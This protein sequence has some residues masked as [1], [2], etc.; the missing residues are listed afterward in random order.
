MSNS[1]KQSESSR[2]KD[3]NSINPSPNSAAAIIKAAKHTL[4]QLETNKIFQKPRPPLKS[5]EFLFYP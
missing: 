2:N 5:F 4:T 3:N 1:N